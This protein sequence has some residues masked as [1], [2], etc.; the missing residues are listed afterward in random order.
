MTDNPKTS[1]GFSTLSGRR[2]FGRTFRSRVDL[3]L[4]PVPPRRRSPDPPGLSPVQD[5]HLCLRL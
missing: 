4:S 2:P 1:S 5:T 3:H